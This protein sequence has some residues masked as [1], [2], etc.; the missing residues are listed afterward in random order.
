MPALYLAVLVSLVVA[1]PIA[2][3]DQSGPA[4]D[5][6]K[7][8]Q[9]M[10][11]GRSPGTFKIP[12]EADMPL[13]L[14]ALAKEPTG[15]WVSRLTL[16]AAKARFQLRSLQGKA[17]QD[18]A[19]R[20]AHLLQEGELI[21]QAAI[22]SDP[23]RDALNDARQS[24]RQAQTPFLIEAGPANFPDVRAIAQDMLDRNK[25]TKSWNYG[26]IV[27]EG[28]VLLGRVA[29]REGNVEKARAC[30]RAAGQS[31]GSPQLGSFGPEL[32]F[33][34]EVLEHGDKLDREAVLGFLKD[35]E[36]F[37]ANPI[38]GNANSQQVSAEHLK[39]LAVWR[40]EIQDGKIPNHPQWR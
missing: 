2:A 20:T 10:K 13:L 28:N 39:Q 32:V 4:V 18:A 7:L 35:I 23:N 19:A 9:F 15:P 27:Y 29:L 14:A 34:R 6:A 25:D 17:R 11:D 22:K 30:L 38:P 26:N 37:W 12:T 24:L 33:A 40:E 3:A 31:P 1:P 8:A 36:H 16:V 21:L 5:T